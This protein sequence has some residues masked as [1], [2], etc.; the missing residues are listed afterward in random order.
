MGLNPAGFIRV[1]LSLSLPLSLIRGLS[2]FISVRGLRKRK[3]QMR[4]QRRKIK[5]LRK[6]FWLSQRPLE[7]AFRNSALSF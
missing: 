6:S 1:S 7:S 4:N 2:T 3:S 5:I